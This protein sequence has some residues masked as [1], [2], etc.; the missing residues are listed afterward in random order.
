[1][2][3]VTP[4]IETAETSRVDFLLT[5]IAEDEEQAARVYE[6]WNFARE[7]YDPL[8]ARALAELAA[9]RRIIERCRWVED[10]PDWADRFDMEGEFAACS[11]VLDLLVAAYEQPAEQLA[12]SVPH[13][14]RRTALVAAVAFLAV[15]FG[16]AGL[17]PASATQPTD[18]RATSLGHYCET[19]NG[20]YYEFRITNTG[21]ARQAVR[22]WITWRGQHYKETF[23][24]HVA[25]G[26]SIVESVRVHKTMR[27]VITLRSQ[28]K[29]I[30]RAKLSG[31]TCSKR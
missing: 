25:P 1:M 10:H 5:R 11:D 24:L 23:G 31:A 12:A 9:K 6:V 18:V 19:Y 22:G 20:T 27:A 30:E 14:V 26:R 15:V 13:A 8:K 3:D 2:N 21:D 7:E 16:L 4:N 28:G 17:S 29:V